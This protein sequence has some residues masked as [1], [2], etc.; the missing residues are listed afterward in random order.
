MSILFVCRSVQRSFR[1]YIDIELNIEKDPL[2]WR[3][4]L[5]HFGAN[6]DIVFTTFLVLKKAS[7]YF[8]SMTSVQMERSETM[9][10][11]P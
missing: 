2:Q 10:S 7:G 9:T 4:D 3:E 5:P 1:I 11:S 8:A 6:T